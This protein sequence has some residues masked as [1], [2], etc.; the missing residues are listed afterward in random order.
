MD[1]KKETKE[2]LSYIRKHPCLV[3][4]ESNVDCDHL[5]IRGMGGR[6]RKG[7]HSGTIIDFSCVPLCRE[8]H[9]QRHS[10]GIKAFGIYHKIDLWKEA[11]LLLRGWYVE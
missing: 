5:Q 11:F 10:I 1:L 4:G 6:G 3:C 7:T 8:H 2:Y 9:T